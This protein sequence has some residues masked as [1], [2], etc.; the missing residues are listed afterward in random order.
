MFSFFFSFWTVAELMSA[1]IK[2][3]GKGRAVRAVGPKQFGNCTG[4][5]ERGQ[6]VRSL[7]TS[8]SALA[9]FHIRLRGA[10]GPNSHRL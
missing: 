5:E 7:S 1:I 2:A 9:F 6:D 10:N 8:M 4:S 3:R